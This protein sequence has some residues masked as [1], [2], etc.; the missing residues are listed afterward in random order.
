MFEVLRAYH[1]N[2]LDWD[3]PSSLDYHIPHQTCDFRLRI[4][5]A[6][7]SMGGYVPPGA[8]VPSDSDPDPQDASGHYTTPK[9]DS[10]DSKKFKGFVVQEL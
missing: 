2:L 6:M 7:M 3:F 10:L 8:E 5:S 9:S 4:Q 1:G